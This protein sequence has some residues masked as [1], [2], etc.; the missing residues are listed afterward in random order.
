VESEDIQKVADESQ[1]QLNLTPPRLDTLPAELRHNLLC[2]LDLGSLW[3]LVHASPVYY[4]QYKEHRD[5]VLPSSMEYT[6][7][8]AYTIRLFRDHEVE[9]RD[10]V[11]GFLKSYSGPGARR[12]LDSEGKVDVFTT[13][14]MARFYFRVVKPVADK[15]TNSALM[16]LRQETGHADSSVDLNLSGSERARITR[17]I[18]RI[19]LYWIMIQVVQKHDFM[20]QFER[21]TAATLAFLDFF[22]PWEVEEINSYYEYAKKTYTKVVGDIRWDVHQDNPKFDGQNRPP[23]PTGAFNLNHG[24]FRT[25][26]LPLAC[27]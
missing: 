22:E 11:A 5:R 1:R 24:K 20:N 23:T 21:S 2:F 3:A 12:R 10:D 25:T 17:A 4:A 9:F 13:V 14:E 19:E 26:H 15:C 27:H 7:P 16:K 6:A 8:E 18:Y